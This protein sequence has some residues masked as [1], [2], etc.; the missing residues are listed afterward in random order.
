M[1]I[2]GSLLAFFGCTSNE[3]KQEGEKVKF[4]QKEGFTEMQ[5]GGTDTAVY[6]L[7]EDSVLFLP[8]IRN[9]TKEDVYEEQMVNIKLGDNIAAYIAKVQMKE[10]GRVGTSYLFKTSLAKYGISENEMLNIALRN[11]GNAKLTIN[12]MN[13]RETGDE[14]IT[15]SS[16]LGMSTSILVDTNFINKLAKDLKTDELHVTIINSGTLFF[17]APN[18]SFEKKFKQM[19]L[20]NTYTDVVNLHSAMYLWQNNSLKLI[21]KYRD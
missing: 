15:V 20:Q 8:V 5:I 7:K 21:E 12:G 14:M 10:N 16:E 2:I 18:S 13:D 1:S 3:A 17:T 6:N 19:A 4:S 9:F 11:L